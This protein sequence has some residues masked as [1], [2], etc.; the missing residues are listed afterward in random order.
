[1]KPINIWAKAVQDH[2]CD[3]PRLQISLLSMRFASAVAE[4][5]LDLSRHEKTV[6]A[7]VANEDSKE[8]QSVTQGTDENSVAEES[9]DT[10]LPDKVFVSNLPAE[11]FPLL[12]SLGIDSE[13]QMDVLI[14]EIVNYHGCKTIKYMQANNRIGF[15]LPLPSA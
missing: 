10:V 2:S 4:S 7:T 13:L 9:G 6:P 15:L 1:M 3:V 5:D 11:Q 12:C 8:E 14:R